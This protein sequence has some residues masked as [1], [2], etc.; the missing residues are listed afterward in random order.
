VVVASFNGNVQWGSSVVLT[1]RYS[2]VGGTASPDA[3]R[4]PVS[5]VVP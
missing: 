4:L 2:Y 1:G 5:I 3:V